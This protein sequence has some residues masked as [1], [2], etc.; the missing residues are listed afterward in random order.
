MAV[1]RWAPHLQLNAVNDGD[2]VF[3]HQQTHNNRVALGTDFKGHYYT[4][5]GSDRRALPAPLCAFF[6]PVM[7]HSLTVAWLWS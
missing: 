3:M 2:I 5:G 7:L 6:L 1:C 4:P